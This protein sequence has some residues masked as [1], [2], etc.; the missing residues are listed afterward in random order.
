LRRK[1]E[2][3]VEEEGGMKEKRKESL[4]YNLILVSPPV[5]IGNMENA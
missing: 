4:P 3:E 1:K 5:M 2:E